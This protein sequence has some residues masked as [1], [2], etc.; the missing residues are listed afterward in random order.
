MDH[1]SQYDVIF[2]S[3]GVPYSEELLPFKDK[4]LT[5]IQFFFNNYKGKVIA[6]TASK[7]KST[8]TSLIYTILKDA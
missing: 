2:K 5:Q 3:A 6:V 8:M 7:G 4:I 1:L